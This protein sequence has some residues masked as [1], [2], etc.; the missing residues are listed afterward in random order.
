M[1]EELKFAEFLKRPENI[2]DEADF[3]I[4]NDNYHALD[5]IIDRFYFSKSPEHPK[6]FSILFSDP[7]FP[8]ALRSMCE[9]Y[10]LK[11]PDR[12]IF[13]EYSKEDVE[14]LIELGIFKEKARSSHKLIVIHSFNGNVCFVNVFYTS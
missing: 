6:I 2:S 13:T 3:D 5:D 12:V 11:K 8:T 14:K 4:M 10:G 9:S 1:Q 7:A